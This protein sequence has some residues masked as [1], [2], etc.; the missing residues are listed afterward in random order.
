MSTTLTGSD[1][2]YSDTTEYGRGPD[3][4]ITDTAENA[5]ITHHTVTLGD[6]QISY[7]AT[8]GHLV[9]V[10]PS[11]SQPAVKIFYVVFTED[12][13]TPLTSLFG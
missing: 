2:P 4:S 11:S 10:D 7:T 13:A 9:T 6:K 12:I 5:A 1:Q 8:A 3:D